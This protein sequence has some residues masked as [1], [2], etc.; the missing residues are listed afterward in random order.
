MVLALL[1]FHSPV[2]SFANGNYSH[3]W[4]ATDALNYLEAGELKEVL[5]NPDL[6]SIIRNGA[7]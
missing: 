3:L 1:A 6:L 5:S 2:D 7:M 4:M